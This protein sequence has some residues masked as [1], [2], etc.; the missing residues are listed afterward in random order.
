MRRAAPVLSKL[1]LAVVLITLAAF[2]SINRTWAASGNTQICAPSESCTIGEFVY[3]DSYTP[4]NSATCTITSRYPDG[5]VLLNAQAM[6]HASEND[7]WYYHTFTAPATLGL[8]RTEVKCTV[9]G[10]L[11][12]LDKSFEVKEE[13]AGSGSSPTADEIAEATWSYSSRSLST[14]GNLVAD[15]WNSA[16]R[17]L[18]GAGLSSGSIATKSDVQSSTTAT[19]TDSDITT[20]KENVRQTRLLVEKIANKP[21]IE[22]T[23]VEVPDLGKKITATEKQVNDLSKNTQ[24]VNS[25]ISLLVL[26]W[27]KLSEDE[28]LT[29]VEEVNKKFGGENDKETSKSIFGSVNYLTK[30]WDWDSVKTVNNQ[31][32]SARDVSFSLQK[33]LETSGKTNVS[34]NKAKALVRLLDQLEDSVGTKSS[35][36]SDLTVFGKF[37]ETKTIAKLLDT[38]TKDVEAVLAKW[39]SYK[40]PEKQK[41]ISAISAKVVEVNKIPSVRKAL[42]SNTA[43]TDKDLK[44]KSYYVLG[45]ISSNKKLLAEKSGTPLSNTWLELGSIVFKTLATNPSTL[46]TQDVEIKYY[47]PPELKEEDIIETDEGLE[48][49]YDTEKNQLFVTGTYSLAPGETKTVSVRTQDIWVIKQAE[50]DSLRKQAEELSKP[51]EKTSFFAQG[52][53]LKTDIDVSLDKVENLMDENVTP[54]TKIRAYR[55]AQIELDAAREKI[56]RLKDLATQASSAG[57]FFGFVGGTQTLA[58]WGL[59]LIVMVGFVSLTVYMRVI[60]KKAQKKKT[61]SNKKEARVNEEERVKTKKPS[62]KLKYVVGLSMLIV[63]MIGTVGGGIGGVLISKAFLM[64]QEAQG[65]AIKTDEVKVLGEAVEVSNAKSQ[66]EKKPIEEI[67]DIEPDESLEETASAESSSESKEVAKNTVTVKETPTGFLNVRKTPGGLEMGKVNPGDTFPVTEEKNGWFE[68]TLPDGSS[69]WVSGKY[70]T[71]SSLNSTD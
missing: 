38:R 57:A 67:E 1:I 6:T 20:I 42:L 43:S 49:K 60:T 14:F 68:I 35:K 19:T 48:A 30:S 3:T 26:R 62:S 23:A 41:K 52:V 70:V 16:T 61:G 71:E 56:D 28:I 5:T 46:I 55:E 32:K 17:T 24:S 4:E 2:V 18:T 47:L 13:V 37:N 29:A 51:L 36:E 11:M 53:T 21:I 50:I 40:Y 65:V 10:D 12:A 66:T 34:L 25:S 39:N 8:Y 9:S 33:G 59:I 69:G 15:I 63:L 45:I 64:P 54:E 7:G 58:V 27:D 31:A 22:T 44:N